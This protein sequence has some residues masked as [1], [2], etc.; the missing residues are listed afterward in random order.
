MGLHFILLLAAL[1]NCLCPARPCIICDPFV[2][3]ALKTME[4][5]YLPG[6]LEPEHHVNFL[7][8]VELEV[9]SFSDLP[10]N[11]DS[12]MGVVDEDTLEQASWSFL[13]D[14]KRITDSDVKGELF[15][16]EILWMLSLQRDIFITLA[17]RFQKEVFCPN[18][19]GTMS[20]TLIW[21]HQCQKQ[22]YFCRKSTDCGER[23]IQVHRLEDL[24]LDCQLSW[25]HASEGLTDYNFYRV[26]ENSSETLMSKGKESYLTKTMVGPEDAGNYRCQ[27]DTVHGEP[28]TVMYYHVT[29]LPP[30]PVEENPPPNVVTQ[31]EQETPV[32]VTA[33]TPEPPPELQPQPQPEPQPEPE[34]EPELIPTIPQRPAKK[35]KTRL[36]IL[37]TLGFVVLVASIVV[38]VLHFRKIRAKWKSS[39]AATKPS[40]TESKLDH[41]SSQQMG[42]KKLSQAEINPDSGDRDEETENE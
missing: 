33:P 39:N 23:Q 26:W 37:L 19:C 38:S 1:A 8:R 2:V 36:L 21:C 27:L 24:V 16:K 18:K 31:E 10:I 20:Q 29:V 5:N 32:Q 41:E 7:K 4:Q 3:A 35:L 11:K 28:A 42:S 40:T 17:A 15:V 34:P 25:H 12:F 13:K 9:K 30:R 22:I 6:H 14:L